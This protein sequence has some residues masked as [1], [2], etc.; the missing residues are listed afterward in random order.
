MAIELQTRL[1]YYFQIRDGDIVT[2]S[3]TG[4]K[5]SDGFES[6][7]VFNRNVFVYRLTPQCDKNKL[8]CYS[9]KAECYIEFATV[10]QITKSCYAEETFD[11][12]E[13]GIRKAIAFFDTQYRSNINSNSFKTETNENK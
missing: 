9:L 3:F 2:N 1:N 10:K 11:Y 5:G 13:E 7:G 12:S 4:S 6:Y 8:L